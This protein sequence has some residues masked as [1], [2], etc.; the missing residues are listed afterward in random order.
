MTI[1]W[2]IAVGFCVVISNALPSAADYEPIGMG[3]AISGPPVRHH[4]RSLEAVTIAQGTFGEPVGNPPLGDESLYGEPVGNPPVGDE[5][6]SGE[7]VGN[8]PIESEPL[9]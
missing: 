3:E 2:I 5:P 8:P 6:L 9:Y 1:R 4:D 7:P